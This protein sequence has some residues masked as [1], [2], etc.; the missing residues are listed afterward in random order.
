MCLEFSYWHLFLFRFNWKMNFD[1]R[2][3]SIWF[4]HKCRNQLT[5]TNV[6]YFILVIFC[7]LINWLI[8]R[9]IDSFF[10]VV[11]VPNTIYFE[12]IHFITIIALRWDMH[13]LRRSSK[14]GIVPIVSERIEDQSLRSKESKKNCT[15]NGVLSTNNVFL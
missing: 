10:V 13:I 9:L 6:F 1:I 7:W 3:D 4:I 2:F 8:D 12:I 15:T 14:T 5:M 11:V